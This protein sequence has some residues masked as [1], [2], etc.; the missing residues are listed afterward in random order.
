MIIEEVS[1][2]D[3]IDRLARGENASYTYE[4]AEALFDYYFDLSEAINENINFD[5]IA[6][7]CEWSEYTEDELREQ[8]NIGHDEDV[9][10]TMVDRDLAH[11][12]IRI[13]MHGRPHHYLV[14]Y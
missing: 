14:Q 7:R 8:Y 6:I 1:R 2:H 4:A 5:R 3:W 12:V 9:E 11:H 10:I 13:P